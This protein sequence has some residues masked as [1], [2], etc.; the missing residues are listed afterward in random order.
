MNHPPHKVVFYLAIFTAPFNIVSSINFGITDI[1]FIICAILLLV[2]G[3]KFKFPDR[4]VLVC[5]L[6]IFFGYMISLVNSQDIVNSL[7]FP[8][9]FLFIICI[10]FPVTYTIVDSLHEIRRIALILFSS[11]LTISGYGIYYSVTYGVTHVRDRWSLFYGNPNDLAVVLTYLIIISLFIFFIYMRRNKFSSLII[12]STIMISSLLLFRTLSRSGIVSLILFL[13]IL[14]VTRAGLINNTKLVI[15]RFVSLVLLLPLAVIL[16]DILGFIPE[17]IFIRFDETINYQDH[18]STNSRV[19]QHFIFLRSLSEF[20]FIGTGYDNFAQTA[21]YARTSAEI[22]YVQ[23]AGHLR[24]HNAWLIAFIE[25][26]LFA[27]IGVFVLF[28]T[29]VFRT[30]LIWWY[31]IKYHFLIGFGFAL[32]VSIYLLSAVFRTLPTVRL[33]WIL[34]AIALVSIN[35]ILNQKTCTK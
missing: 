20:L 35:I 7:K 25:G 21:S 1:L 4:I 27:G 16:L 2:H 12:L 33:H 24:L 19:H 11:L 9:Q 14:F 31:G 5:L 15:Q 22:E 10:I 13:I 32:S 30:S 17:G 6:S 3:D 18:S 26:G 8:L 29:I 28:Y 34:I 23:S